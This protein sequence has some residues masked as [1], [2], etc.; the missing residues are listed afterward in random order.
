[1]K[2][3]LCLLLFFLLA[4]CLTACSTVTTTT[5]TVDPGLRRVAGAE[6]PG[7]HAAV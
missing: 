4:L 1:M 6:T 2:K 3:F 7:P 5:G